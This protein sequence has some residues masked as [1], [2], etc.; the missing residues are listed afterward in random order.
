MMNEHL[1]E[2]EKEKEIAQLKFLIERYK[3]YDKRRKEYYSKKM[4][5]L[6]ELE[7]L[8][9][10]IKDTSLPLQELILKQK[11]EIKRFNTIFKVHSIEDNRTQ[12]ELVQIIRA[13]EYKR[14]NK[15]LREKIKGLRDTI[16]KLIS[17]NLKLKQLSDRIQ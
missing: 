14:Q 3:E 16:D 1:F 12:D 15:K 13:D 10:E 11:Q 2:N 9:E 6:G 8:L 4:Q 5:R 7:S 17:E